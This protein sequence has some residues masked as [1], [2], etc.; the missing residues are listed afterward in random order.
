MSSFAFD[1]SGAVLPPTPEELAEADK[2]SAILCLTDGVLEDGRPY[3][4]YV[5]VKPSLYAEFHKL[6]NDRQPMIVGNYGEII[7]AGYAP[8]PP[9]EVVREMNENYGFDDSY[10]EKLL[11]HVQDEYREFSAKQEDMRIKDIVSMLQNQQK[12]SDK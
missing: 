9:P 7:M 10:K 8:S 5:A 1:S 3:Y 12:N 11:K 6:T 2:H 4:A